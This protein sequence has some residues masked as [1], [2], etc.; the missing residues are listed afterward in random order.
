LTQYDYE[1]EQARLGKY[2]EK[3]MNEAETKFRVA[4]EAAVESVLSKGAVNREALQEAMATVIEGSRD[5]TAD[6][7]ESIANRYLS[8][9]LEKAGLKPAKFEDYSWGKRT[10]RAGTI[11]SGYYK[12]PEGQTVFVPAYRRADFL[13]KYHLSGE[14]RPMQVWDIA[15]ECAA[16]AEERIFTV[17]EGGRALGRDAKDIGKDLEIFIKHKNGGER[18]IGRWGGMI[19]PYVMKNGNLVRDE[20]KIL[21]GWERAYL[22]SVNEGLDPLGEDYIVYSSREARDILE[23][24]QAQAWLK[25][26]IGA[27]GKMLLPPSAKR[28]VARL[29][30]AG[31]DYRAIR[32][33]RTESAA[34]FNDRQDR[35]AETNPA[36]TGR[37]MRRLGPHRDGWGCLCVEAARKCKEAGGWKPIEIEAQYRA[38][39]HPNCDCRDEP[40]LLGVEDMMER[41]FKKYG[42]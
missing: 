11:F 23:S 29:G 13:R 39:L 15:G 42:V 26:K 35:L 22:A 8:D 25:T 27:K 16:E 4:L 12:T 18:V 31:L 37:I 28:Y 19:S 10:S 1:R 21:E 9:C 32:V 7:A 14:T 33:L 24:P 2:S 40:I 34:A 36:A 41:I 17:L 38:P 6:R 3:V 20:K 5:L 30:K